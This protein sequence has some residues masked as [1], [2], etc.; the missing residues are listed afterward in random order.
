MSDPHAF[1]FMQIIYLVFCISVFG[2]YTNCNSESEFWN[3]PIV[4]FTPE[5]IYSKCYTLQKKHDLHIEVHMVKTK[6]CLYLVEEKVLQT[7]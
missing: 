6:W 3:C 4:S 7:L 5:M 2:K 1:V